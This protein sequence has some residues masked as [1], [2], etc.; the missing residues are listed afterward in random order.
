M[1]AQGHLLSVKRGILYRRLAAGCAAVFLAAC[2]D[3][4]AAPAPAAAG[5]FSGGEVKL[6]LSSELLPR[7][8]VWFD[9]AARPAE[10]AITYRLSQRDSLTFEPSQVPIALS[11]QLADDAYLIQAEDANE[12]GAVVG[13][14]ISVGSAV[15]NLDGGGFDGDAPLP[16]DWMRYDGVD[17]DRIEAYV[18]LQ[19]AR[20]STAEAAMWIWA[21][22]MTEGEGGT[23][24]AA[25]PMTPT[26]GWGDFEAHEA[27]LDKHG[28]SGTHSIFV[29]CMGSND[30]GV[31]NLDYISFTPAPPA[32]PPSAPVVIQVDPTQTFQSLTGL[33]TS[34]ED[35]SLYAIL[36][37]KTDEQRRALLRELFDPETGIGLNLVRITIGT[38][39][40]AD[41]RAAN[42]SAYPWY[43]YQDGES[44][45]FSIEKDLRTYAGEPVALEGG[46]PAALRLAQEVALE[47]GNP[48]TFFASPWSP[49]GW[50][51]TSGS[52]VGGTLREGLEPRLAQYLR[53]FVEAYQAEGIPIHAI[54]LQNERNFVPTAYPGMQLTN[55][56]EAALVVAT[57]ENFHNIDGEHGTRLDTR[58]WIVDHNF[59][60]V[61]SAIDVMDLLAAEGKSGYV[62]AAAFHHYGGSPEQMQPFAAR[63]PATDLQFTEGAVWGVG[64]SAGGGANFQEVASILRNGAKS[65]T[66]WVPMVTYTP[67][68]HIQGPYNSPGVL[69]PAL[70]M[71]DPDDVGF[72]RTPELFLFGQFSK[73]IRPGAVRIASGAGTPD[74]LTT[75]AFQ[76]RDGK[77]ALVAV[78]S[79][80][81]DQQ[82]TIG[83]R[84]YQTTGSVPV[85]SVATFVWTDRPASAGGDI[86]AGVAGDAGGGNIDAGVGGGGNGGGGGCQ[87]GG[88]TGSSLLAAAALALAVLAR[89]RV[90]RT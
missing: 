73:F 51:K 60:Q 8:A 17:F 89:R 3:A 48:L 26:P 37:N 6:Y 50:M 66:Y 74:S 59:D 20:G 31:G 76:N 21:D 5:D 4:G 1:N 10:S 38:S 39:D 42:G 52:M 67:S 11:A 77:V 68:E 90:T 29:V 79:S 24:L 30:S 86:D 62:D 36:K 80:A 54:T 9:A 44:D 56:Q 88:R 12:L 33:G 13:S 53:N 47:K 18:N 34:L 61:Q 25:V 43:S 63:Y 16:G 58:L 78:N 83:Y 65:Y 19:V 71:S 14:P 32:Q 35:T 64:T 82:I 72:I 57:Y 45:A 84:G 87:V 75:V 23:L 49:P 81:F 40:F 22:F 70:I 41:G 2:S 85:G 69:S 7:Q 55:E 27:V 46:I 15:G 28:L